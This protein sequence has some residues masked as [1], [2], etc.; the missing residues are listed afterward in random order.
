MERH[1]RHFPRLYL[2]S[3]SAQLPAHAL[4]LHALQAV[5][6]HPNVLQRRFGRVIKPSPPP[7]PPSPD[8]LRFFAWGFAVVYVAAGGALTPTPAPISFANSGLITVAALFVTVHTMGRTQVVSNLCHKVLQSAPYNS[9]AAKINPQT[10]NP[11]PCTLNPSSETINSTMNL[12][13]KLFPLRL[14]SNHVFMVFTF[15]QAFGN[16]RNPKW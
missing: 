15:I 9:P 12:Y 13:P 16:S 2:V 11:K 8:C 7:H 4:S 5:E 10:L 14:Y 1:T 3:S 6:C